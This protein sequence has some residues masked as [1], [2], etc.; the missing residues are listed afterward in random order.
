MCQKW[1]TGRR[2]R[3]L[4]IAAAASSR[5][6]IEWRNRGDSTPAEQLGCPGFDPIEQRR[7][8]A[9]SR[10][11]RDGRR[12]T[13]RRGP[14]PPASPAHRRRS[15]RRRRS[16]PRRRRQDR[17]PAGSTPGGGST[18]R[19]SAPRRRQSG[20]RGAPRRPR[21][22]RPASAPE[23][24]SRRGGPCRERTQSE[25]AVHRSAS[26][27]RSRRRTPPMWAP[28]QRGPSRTREG[29]GRMSGSASAMMVSWIRTPCRP[30]RSCASGRD[31]SRPPDGRLV[32]RRLDRT[33]GRHPRSR[34][35]SRGARVRHGL[36]RGRAPVAPG[37]RQAAGLV[38]GRRHD[39][40]RRGGDLAGE[41][42][43]VGLLGAPPQPGHHRQGRRDDR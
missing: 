7:A 2:P 5:A 27:E 11:A 9:A 12:P 26:R 28:C 35:A 23:T 4:A 16:R 1:R 10:G 21:R 43:H 42:R 14:A 29:S 30:R 20:R 37:R 6:L 22:R 19:S 25:P 36:D 41:G 24:C 13:T 33:L 8:D 31:R 18:R 15:L 38:G 3:A 32:R 34:G 17:S 39:R 40:R